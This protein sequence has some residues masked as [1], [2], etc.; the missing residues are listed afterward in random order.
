M[1]FKFFITLIFLMPLYSCDD[2]FEI[3]EKEKAGSIFDDKDISESE[4]SFHDMDFLPT[5]NCPEDMALVGN[6]CVD[7]YEASRSDATENFEGVNEEVAVSRAGVIPWYTN[8][9]SGDDVAIFGKACE[10]AGKRLCKAYEWFDICRGPLKNEYSF[11]NKFNNKIC[12]NVDTFC[13]KYCIDNKVEEKKCNISKNCGYNCGYDLSGI[14][15]FRIL[16]SGSMAECKNEFEV[17]D[18]NGNLWEVVLS[19]TD[20]R[21][22]E[23]RGGAFNCAEAE[24]RLRCVFNASWN[25]LY[26]GFRCCRDLF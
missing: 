23:L 7:R 18:I 4:E 25:S 26:A 12:N 5:E 20:S 6:I 21:G 19:E 15:C 22:F 10:N 17:F 13:S 3:T 8:P 24:E 16:P 9:V 14:K 1:Y 11:G 2:G